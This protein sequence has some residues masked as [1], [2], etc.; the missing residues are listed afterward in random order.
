MGADSCAVSGSDFDIRADPKLFHNGPFLI[1]F[2]SSYRMGQLLRYKLV[3]PRHS[4]SKDTLEYMVTGFI[5]AVR[6]TLRDGG[7]MLTQSGREE[8]GIFMVGYRGQLYVVH[9]D[10]QVSCTTRNFDAIGSGYAYAL[11]SLQ[12]DLTSGPEARLQQALH[13][14][15]CLCTD[16]KAPFI[17]ETSE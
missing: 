3:V 16:V 13:A 12:T 2:T 6:V 4:K 5:E 8:A 15:A 7:Y 1:G 11:G 9:T 10:L 14:A 17:Y